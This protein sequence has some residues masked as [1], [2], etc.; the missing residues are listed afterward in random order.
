MKH[1][2]IDHIGMQEDRRKE[3]SIVKKNKWT[4]ALW[5]KATELID[6]KQG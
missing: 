3:I 4:S 1:Y 6:K 2:F 5:P